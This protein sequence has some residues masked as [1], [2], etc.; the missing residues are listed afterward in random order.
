LWWRSGD[1]KWNSECWS[2]RDLEP[3]M[4]ALLQPKHV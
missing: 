1:T 3:L 4:M 2:E